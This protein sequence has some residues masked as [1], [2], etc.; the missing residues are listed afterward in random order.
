M[1]NRLEATRLAL[2][3]RQPLVGMTE[4]ELQMALGK[5]EKVNSHTGSGGQG[6]QRIYERNGRTYYVYT[7]GTGV[8]TSIQDQEPIKSPKP[9]RPTRDTVIKY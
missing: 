9:F 1:A 4:D 5:P 3:R 8:V 2:E 7:D 6:Q